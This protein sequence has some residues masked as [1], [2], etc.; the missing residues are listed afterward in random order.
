MTSHSPRELVEIVYYS[1]KKKK[2][3]RKKEIV[4]SFHGTVDRRNDR[5]ATF[6]NPAFLRRN[7]LLVAQV[8]HRLSYLPVL[9]FLYC[10]ALRRSYYAPAYSLV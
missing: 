4:Y 2:K 3:K 10:I 1:K 5:P 7:L 9:D 6:E 8:V